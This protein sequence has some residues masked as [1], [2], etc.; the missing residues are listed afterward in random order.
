M[1]ESIKKW[2]DEEKERLLVLVGIVLVG[3]LCFEAGLLQGRTTQERSLVLTL[4]PV[5]V[6]NTL[7][8]GNS[9]SAQSPI[10]TAPVE[11]VVAKESS[12]DCVFVG[13]KNSNKYHL[14]TCAVAKRIK[15]ENRVCFTSKE[16]AEK[17]GYIPSCLK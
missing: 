8:S 14:S 12:R 10:K 6:E 16:D 15:S 9:E 17:R 13:S 7:E 5:P 4:P 3:I 1:K 11:R 2:L